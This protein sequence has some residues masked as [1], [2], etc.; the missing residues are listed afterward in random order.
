M[1]ELRDWKLNSMG[2][3][4]YW[5]KD[6]KRIIITLIICGLLPMFI[7]CSWCDTSLD[8]QFISLGNQHLNSLD[9]GW[10]YYCSGC[11]QYWSLRKETVFENSKVSLKCWITT[12]YHIALDS[13]HL[14]ASVARDCKEDRGWSER[15]CYP[16]LFFIR[17]CMARF[18]NDNF[19][20]LGFHGKQV[21]IDESAHSKKQ[22]H[23]VGDYTPTR[24]VF[25]MIEP[26]SGWRKYVYVA[27]RKRRTLLPIIKHYIARGAVI[28]SDCWMAYN[29]LSDEGYNHMQV[30]HSYEFRDEL[31]GA[32]T[33]NIEATWKWTKRFVID[34]GGCLD[35]HLQLML[36]CY[37]FRAMWINNNKQNA[38]RTVCKAIAETHHN[39]K[40]SDF[41]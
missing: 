35:E 4:A 29:T 18:Y 3:W 38:F 6:M 34:V 41:N 5:T 9:E 40:I 17:N 10:G 19:P 22:K 13:K 21:Q 2:D 11:K 8:A 27:D 14:A 15:R 33:D 26:E 31:T 30:N 12:I 32:H 37:S 39:F 20:L 24:W 1:S 7:L 25:G 23:N 16:V 28:V 36:D